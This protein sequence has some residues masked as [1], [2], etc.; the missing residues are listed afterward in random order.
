[1]KCNELKEA[2][3]LIAKA[4]TDPRVGPDQGNQLL[5]ARRELEKA[6]R[7]GKVDHQ[8]VFRA[9]QLIS[10]VLLEIVEDKATQRSK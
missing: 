8:Q 9:V 3:R 1:M 2:L 10:S 7:S 6:A 4:L 5:K